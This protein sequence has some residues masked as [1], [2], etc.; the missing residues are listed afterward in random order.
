MA[1]AADEIA[2]KKKS[3]SAAAN[4]EF[5]NY[6]FHLWTSKTPPIKYLAELLRD[7]LTEGNL[8]CNED[9]IKLLSTDPSRSVLV[10]L[11]LHVDGFESYKCENPLVLGLNLEDFFKIIKNMENS[12][13][14]RLFVSKSDTNVIG[15]ERYNK[16]ENIYNTIYQS[17]MD[18]ERQ[19]Q[20]IPP[21]KFDNVI[22][23]NS[24]R[25][26][27]ICREI[28]QFSEQIEITSVGNQLIFRGYNS[29]VK[30]EIKIKPTP[31]GMQYEENEK[32]DK[33]V[34]GV[35]D[36]K[37]L[38]QFSKCANLDKNIRIHFKNDYPLVIQCNVAS[39]GTIRLCLAPKLEDK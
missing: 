22:I 10:H 18:I 21:A 32:S 33:I 25:F 7:L 11:N 8:E 38:V 35:F 9:G 6:A 27:K 17:L 31:D 29:N 37:Y 26:Q 19:N 36:L 13:T 3:S 39:L 12:D 16:D 30:Q 34:Q 14:L 20:T 5:A 2:P 4:A 23:M 28:F 15:I 1:A 24:S